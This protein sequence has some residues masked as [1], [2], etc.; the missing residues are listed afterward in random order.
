MFE[1]FEDLL[2]FGFVAV[3]MENLGVSHTDLSQGVT[4][5][6]PASLAWSHGLF[7]SVV[8]SVAA[9]ALAFVFLRNRRMAGIV[10]LVVFSHWVLDFIV[11]P[12]ELPLLF[13]NLQSAGLGL[14]TSGAG[15]LI[16]GIL[17]LGLLA[18]GIAIY[19]VT[20]K[21]TTQLAQAVD[22]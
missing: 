3:G 6:S 22:G 5:L 7:M 14:W 12:A 20:R 21:R 15:L 4:M 17:E 1:I 2:C 11:H 18:G 10:G 13:N 9:A 19:L 8:W 16:S